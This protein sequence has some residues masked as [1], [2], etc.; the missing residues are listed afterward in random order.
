VL[1]ATAHPSLWAVE[2]HVQ[3]M[4]VA[5]DHVQSME[6]NEI[7]ACL[8]S[9]A[10]LAEAE[11]QV[12]WAE[13]EAQVRWPADCEDEPEPPAG[14]DDLTE[15]WPAFRRAVQPG[16]EVWWFSTVRCRGVFGFGKRGF[17][18]VR[19]GRVLK[20]YVTELVC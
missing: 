16:D 8:V 7:Q 9:R 10:S 11:A 13:A 19:Q 3:S 15:N 6:V 18:I 14:V 4:E 17:A 20:W 12:R 2:D 5:V 1:G